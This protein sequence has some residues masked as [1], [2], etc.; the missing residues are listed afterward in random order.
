M[1]NGLGLQPA[2]AALYGA[3]ALDFGVPARMPHHAHH[4]SLPR[5]D[6]HGIPSNLGGGLR[7]APIQPT[8]HEPFDINKLFGQTSSTINPAQLH[9]ASSYIG[10]PTTPFSA[11]FPAFNGL[12]IEDDDFVNGFVV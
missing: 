9:S 4:P 11:G 12:A 10:S 5:I 3:N 8:G 7:T 6:T 2:S 1:N